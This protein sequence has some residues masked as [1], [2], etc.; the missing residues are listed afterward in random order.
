ML[1]EIFDTHAHYVSRQ[2]DSDR[3]ELL[4]SLPQKLSLIHI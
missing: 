3:K 1:T 2:F 4:D